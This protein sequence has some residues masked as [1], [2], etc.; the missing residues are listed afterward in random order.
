MAGIE[1][2]KYLRETTDTRF[3]R[4]FARICIINLKIKKRTQADLFFLEQLLATQRYNE[5]YHHPR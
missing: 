1:L 2:P 3:A 4:R 5:S